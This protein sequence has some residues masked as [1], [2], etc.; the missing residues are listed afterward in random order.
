[1]ADL[2]SRLSPAL[3]QELR[4]VWFAH[5]D[6]LVCPAMG[7]LKQWFAKDDAFDATCL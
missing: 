7:Q 4:S 3:F 2:S 5:C 6:S 1:M